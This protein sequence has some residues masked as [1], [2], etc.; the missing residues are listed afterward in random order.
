MTS[1]QLHARLLT[2][3]QIFAEE[4]GEDEKDGQ[5]GKAVYTIP[6]YQRNY[7]W[8]AEQIEQLISDIQDAIQ[9][10]DDGYFLGNLIVTKRETSGLDF[11]VIDGQQ[12]LIT[13]YMLW[14]ILDRNRVRQ[15]R[16]PVQYESRPRSKA[17]LARVASET[18]P[19]KAPILDSTGSEDAAIL[20]GF[21]VIQQFLEQHRELRDPGSRDNLAKYLREKVTVVRA[22]LPSQNDLNRYFEIMNTRGQQLQQV[23]IVKARLMSHLPNEA[24][25]GCFAWIWDACADMDSYVQMSLTRGDTGLRNDLFGGHGD[26]THRWSWLTAKGFDDLRIGLGQ[27]GE[28]GQETV[29]GSPTGATR[30][31]SLTLDEALEKYARGAASA[32]GEDVDNVRFRSTIEFPSFLLHVLKIVNVDRDDQE[33]ESLLDDKRLIRRFDEALRDAENRGPAEASEWVRH[34]AFQLLKYRN[35]FDGFILKRQYTAANSDVGDWSLQRL[36]KR[37]AQDKSKLGYL[38]TFSTGGSGSGAEAIA[39]VEEDGDVDLATRDV[40]LIQSMLRVTYTSPRTMHWIT[41]LL[42]FLGENEPQKVTG[43][44][45]VDLLRDY[46]R[47]RVREAFFV[48][49]PPTGFHINRIVFT[50]LDYLLLSDQPR[51]YYRFAFR[52]SIE[53]FYPQHPAEDQDGPQVTSDRLNSLGNLALVSVSANSKFGNSLP[54]AKAGN[55]ESTILEQ[56]PKLRLMADIT[57]A[58]GWGDAQVSAHHAEMVERLHG[59]VHATPLKITHQH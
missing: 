44:Q 2:V 57:R 5:D 58:G 4:D 40:L 31:T 22:S 35:L 12:R 34:F 13:L 11:E 36:W 46:A 9:D 37:K 53:H 21:N 42:E 10:N 27:R 55:F 24:E 20:E 16:P 3:G 39:R 51:S 52:N 8:R 28:D 32:T 26:E 23:D 45:I 1:H 50:Y 19:G 18:S 38:N 41:G 15:H 48:A 47:G 17:A 56:S 54:D 25:R 59:D 43:T 14:T 33:Q 49:E 29:L 6:I 30:S 7:A